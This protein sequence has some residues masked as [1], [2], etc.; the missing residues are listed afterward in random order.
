MYNTEKHRI[1]KLQLW[2]SVTYVPDP[3]SH[4]VVV[5]PLQE[6]VYP[7]QEAVYPHQGEVYHHLGLDVLP[8]GL[9]YPLFDLHELCHP[10]RQV[11]D[12]KVLKNMVVVV[13]GVTNAMAHKCKKDKY[14]VRQVKDEN[15]DSHY[16]I[17]PSIIYVRYSV[18]DY[19]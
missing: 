3:C 5:C 1:T 18:S 4:W 15:D 17:I 10:E 13:T 12:E 8:L 14:G 7:H 11:A 6:V 16:N 19:Q 9:V 2:L